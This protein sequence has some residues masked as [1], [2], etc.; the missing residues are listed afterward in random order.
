MNMKEL[1]YPKE[2]AMMVYRDCQLNCKFCY[3]RGIDIDLNPKE[4]LNFYTNIIKSYEVDGHYPRIFIGGIGEPTL[5]RN[6]SILK[7]LL[8]RFP[9]NK[10]VLFSNLVEP[11][12]TA[13]LVKEYPNLEKIIG[14]II[15]E[16]G[17]DSYLE[18]KSRPSVEEIICIF[19]KADV[20][21]RLEFEILLLS[22][23]L[24]K[25]F[26]RPLLDGHNIPYSYAGAVP[27]GRAI[28]TGLYLSREELIKQSQLKGSPKDFLGAINCIIIEK[29]LTLLGLKV[30][31]CPGALVNEIYAKYPRKYAAR[32][33]NDK[34]ELAKLCKITS[35]LIVM[36]R[37]KG[38]SLTNMCIGREILYSKLEKR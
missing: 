6:Y 38:I 3:T 9:K 14:R 29:G 37:N 19:R 24:D 17:G 5:R 4:L 22:S 18:G 23:N 27:L 7:K 16:R 32:L 1:V 35:D 13:K 15:S 28:E 11:K 36:K 26:P 8:G 30:A 20:L 21:D 10:F 33:I 25:K 31:L 2:I 34:K 12:K